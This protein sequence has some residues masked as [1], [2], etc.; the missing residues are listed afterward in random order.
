MHRNKRPLGP[1]LVA[2]SMAAAVLGLAWTAAVAQDSGTSGA[3]S[4]SGTSSATGS[5]APPGSASPSNTMSSAS[6]FG[7]PDPSPYY[8]G[9]SQ[10]FTHDTNVYRVPN[11]V[12]DTY[13]ST[14]LFGGFDQP[15]SRQRVFG[16]AAVTGHLYQHESDLNNVSYAL[17][18]GLAW[19]TI[20]KLS[21]S[22]NLRLNRDLA[23]PAASSLPVARQNIADTKGFD[24]VARYGGASLLS[25]EGRV[26]YSR[27]DY[28]APEYVTSESRH[29]TASLGV[30]YWP[31]GPL[32]LGVAARVDRTE[33]PQALFDPA[34]G[35]F[36]P[37]KINGRNIDLL[38]DY[39]VTGL[40]SADVRLSYTKQ[41]NTNIG[42]SDFSG[43]TGSIGVT[44][45]PTEKT[46]VRLDASRDA[47]FDTDLYTDQLPGNT[48]D[49]QPSTVT[50]LY[51]NNEVTN[52]A[53]ASVSYAATSKVRASAGARYLRA[54]L[55]TVV[56]QG[57]ASASSG[58]TDRVTSAYISANYEITRS[59]GVACTISHENREVSGRVNYSYTANTFACLTQ[60][61][62]R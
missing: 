51:E 17:S 3:T 29:S 23:A 33:T 58:Q 39:D 9:A 18:T 42:E 28:S 55:S 59:W 10:A 8:I 27:L 19:E 5:A 60:I 2:G 61:T 1:S 34:T 14:S 53:S 62:L 43:W 50:G 47:G 32:R 56:A 37:N 44:W 30:Y 49:P 35:T 16:R 38:A 26:G 25:L 57:T 48:L 11:G 46:S 4:G 7:S 21:G 45:R 6:T 24:A 13:S 40:V 54:N 15:I 36:L 22:I 52:S 41:T 31:G 12:S 20:N